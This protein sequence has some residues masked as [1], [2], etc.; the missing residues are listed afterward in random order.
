MIATHLASQ[1]HEARRRDDVLRKRGCFGLGMALVGALIGATAP[2]AVFAQPAKAVKAQAADC[3]A[4]GKVNVICGIA[5]AEDL[6]RIPGSDWVVTS[7][8]ERNGIRFVNTRDYRYMQVFPAPTAR[9]AFDRQKFPDCPGPTAEKA[10]DFHGINLRV[11][12][13]GV[14][15]LYAVRHASQEAGSREAI[16]VFEIDARQKLPS[17][18]WIGCA[19]APAGVALNSVT[20]LPGDGF[21]SSNFNWPENNRATDFPKGWSNGQ[22]WEWQP[23]AKWKIVP[24]SEFFPGPNGLEASKDGKW[25]YVNLWPAMRVLRLSRGQSPVK[26]DLI[27]VPFHPDNIHWNEDGSLLVAGQGARDIARL[28]ECMDLSTHFGKACQDV[29]AEVVRLDPDSLSITPVLSYPGRARVSIATV[30]LAVGKDIWLSSDF[31]D[32]IVRYPLP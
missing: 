8:L 21:I 19:P 25:L 9:I 24:G 26:V 7:G 6:Q 18:T 15:T 20:P 16:E 29:T 1:A 10:V 23:G 5:H 17:V 22:L 2:T 32:R 28:Q 11:G 12:A 4:D 13:N 27:D 14:H 3:A 31:F 30:G